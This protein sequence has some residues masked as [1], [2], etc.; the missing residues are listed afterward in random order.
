MVS[1]TRRAKA[2]FTLKE[3][4]AMRDRSKEVFHKGRRVFLI[5]GTDPREIV[6]GRAVAVTKEVVV[7]TRPVWAGPLSFDKRTGTPTSDSFVSRQLI[8]D[9]ADIA[10]ARAGTLRLA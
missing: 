7:V 10:Q 2:T 1:T 4:T 3:T 5:E 9:P 6:E 8:T